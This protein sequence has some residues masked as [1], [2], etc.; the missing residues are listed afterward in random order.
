M[1]HAEDQ[2][3]DKECYTDDQLLSF[4]VGIC[5]FLTESHAIMGKPP[6]TETDSVFDMVIDDCAE[7]QGNHARLT[8]SVFLTGQEKMAG[9]V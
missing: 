1:I 4:S 9:A 8:G 6:S 7:T 3:S 5:T 2:I